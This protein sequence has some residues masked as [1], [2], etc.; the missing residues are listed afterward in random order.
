MSVQS[1]NAETVVGEKAR[2]A[3]MAVKRGSFI[4]GPWKAW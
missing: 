1:G 2:R 4:F 3:A